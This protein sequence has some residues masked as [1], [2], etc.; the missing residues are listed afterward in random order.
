MNEAHELVVSWKVE[1]VWA[2]KV[3]P[4]ALKASGSEVAIEALEL[5]YESASIQRD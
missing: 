1:N 3:Q 5:A 4:P 2:M